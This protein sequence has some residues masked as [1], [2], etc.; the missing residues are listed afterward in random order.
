MRSPT[1][2]ENPTPSPAA[3]RGRPAPLEVSARF[4]RG[5]LLVFAL[6]AAGLLGK[7]MFFARVAT[8]DACG[9]YLPLAEAVAQG[10]WAE[11]QHPMIPPVYPFVVGM[12]ARG[13][14]FWVQPADSA[15]R[16]V[17]AASVLV[18]L[19]LIYG[20]GQSLFSRR[21]GLAAAGLVAANRWII[22]FG[23]NVGPAMLYA[24][25]LALCV[26]ALIRY[27]RAP[28]VVWAATA[29]LAAAA[30]AMTRSEG[31]FLP[32]LAMIVLVIAALRRK[33]RPVAR[34]ALHAGVVIVLVAVVCWPRLAYMHRTSGAAVLDVRTFQLLDRDAK[35]NPDWWRMPLAKARLE[36]GRID[37]SR[38]LGEAAQEAAETIGMVIGPA[39]WLLALIWLLGRKPGPQR[40]W[41]QLLILTVVLA[42]ILI[43]APVKMDR[44]YVAAVAGPAQIWGALGMV[45]LAERLRARK[46]WTGRFGASLGRQLV[47]LGLLL[48]GLACWSVLSANVGTRHRELA[49]LGRAIRTAH[50]PGGIILGTSPEP[51]Y[52]AGGR[53]V[54]LVTG[55]AGEATLSPGEL[56][57]LCAAHDVD[58]IVIRSDET[59]APWLIRRLAAPGPPPEYLIASG[60]TGEIPHRGDGPIRSY[61]IDARRLPAD[62][63]SHETHQS[64]DP[65]DLGVMEPVA[66]D[67]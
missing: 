55:D 59:W 15:G 8:E 26:L 33:V 35:P 18:L 53:L 60:T 6:L 42:E 29:A 34:V 48:A 64:V 37:H 36:L 32:V 54:H 11:A 2:P 5:A 12:L 30:A 62:L 25:F 10:R 14:P 31:I 16:I 45:A 9:F 23:A 28:G 3:G 20:I 4:G 47:A 24:A 39:T 19:P 7:Q 1:P 65:D 63:S 41:G 13:L 61:V 52:Y 58:F 17:S 67:R 49:S 56:A 38:P 43:V 51:A 66:E 40:P 44:R 57:A 46:G 50:S 21:V 22:Y 27:V